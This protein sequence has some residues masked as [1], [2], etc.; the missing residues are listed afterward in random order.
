[1]KFYAVMYEYNPNHPRLDDVRPKHREFIGTLF[2]QDQIVGSGPFTDSKGGALIILQLNEET[3]MEDV[4]TIMDGDP[5][6]IEELVT[7]REIR[8]WSPK[9]AVF[10]F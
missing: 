5:Y 6:W 3:T 9:S 10:D 7:K 4:I 1:M 8:E 2:N